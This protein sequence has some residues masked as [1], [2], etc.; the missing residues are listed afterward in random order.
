MKAVPRRLAYLGAAFALRLTLLAWGSYQDRT[1]ALPYTDVDYFVFRDAAELVVHGC[2]LEKTVKS[3]GYE[4][5]FDL[6]ERSD[7]QCARGVLPAAARFL[8][9]NDPINHADQDD[10]PFQSTS[11]L[12]RSASRCYAVARPFFHALATVGDPYARPTYRYTPWLAVVLSPIHLFNSLNFG[13]ILFAASDLACVLLMW[14]IMDGRRPQGS[15]AGIYDHL[16]GLMWGLN[17]F[18]AQISTRGSSES[19]VG[20]TVLM[21]VYYFLKTNPEAPL[22]LQPIHKE[23]DDTKTKDP[24]FE[25]GTAQLDNAIYRPMVPEN[26]L[27]ILDWSIEAF[28]GPIMHGIATHFKLFP[29]IYGV[30]VLAHL[31]SSTMSAHDPSTRRTLGFWARHTAGLQFGLVSFITFMTINVFTWAM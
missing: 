27:P 28:L 7:V 2:P 11:L 6:L 8:L 13:K 4:T 10:S 9:L 14:L 1:Q 23:V 12:F 19:L 31:Y 18:P 25:T 15:A 20:L 30:P 26:A 24:S 16:P 5:D 17:P 29:V 21:F 22:G 3:V